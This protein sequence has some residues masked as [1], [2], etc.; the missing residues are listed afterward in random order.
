MQAGLS[1][2]VTYRGRGRRDERRRSTVVL[3]RVVDVVRVVVEPVIVDVQVRRIVEVAVSI[4]SLVASTH[5]V[6]P[7]LSR[8]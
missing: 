8:L 5:Q 1:G 2:L 6:S 7:Q 4:G 3:I